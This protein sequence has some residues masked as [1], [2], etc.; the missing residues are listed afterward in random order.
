MKKLLVTGVLAVAA[1]ASI[2]ATCV[3]RNVSLEEIDG[4]A[5]YG[6]ELKN[7][8]TVDFLGHRFVVAFLDDD[9][10]VIETRTVN[11]CLR[12]LQANTSNFYSATYSDDPDDV[13]VA[14]S[15][16]ALDGSLE[17]GQTAPGDLELSD[18]EAVRDGETLT[19]TGTIT[20]DE[21]DDLEDVR[22][23]VVVYNEDGGVLRVQR[24][25]ETFDME[26]GDSNGFTI[27]VTVPDDDELVDHVSVWVDGINVDEDDTPSEPVGKEDVDVDI[28]EATPTPTATATA[29]AT[30]TPE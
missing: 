25:A 11:G 19:V 26:D 22:A 12:S 21:S 18:V 3:V 6:A 28:A 4:D 27:E 13:E 15:R 10:D 9:L 17:V 24:D 1:L 14:L 8:T 7:E 5:I 16:I 23:C 2:A 20:S 29:T 30:A